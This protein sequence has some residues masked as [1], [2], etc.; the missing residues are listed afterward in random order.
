MSRLIKRFSFGKIVDRGEMPHFLEFQLNSY[1]DF[2]QAGIPPQKRENQGLENIFQEI[3]PIESSNGQLKLEYIWYEIHE[4]DKPLNDELECKKRRKTYAGQLKVRLRLINL[5]TEEIQETLVYFGEI[6]LMTDK[7]TFIINGAERVVVSQLHRSPGVTFNKELSIQTGKDIFIGKIIPYKGTWLEFETDKNDILNVKIDRRK[8]VLS[9]I[10]LKSVD[11]FTNNREIMDQFFES[12]ELE[13]NKLYEKY[14]GDDLQEVIKNRL[15][16]SFNKE[17][18]LDEKTGEFVLESEELIDEIGIEKLI[19]NKVEK[20]YYWEVKPEDRIIA[21]SLIHDHT[22]T[23]DEAVVEVF[24]KLRPGDLVT[25]DSARSLLK[26]MFFNP[27]RYDLANVGRYKIN[28][29]LKL[30]LP[31]NEI[32]LTKEDVMQTINYVRNLYNDDGYTDD[33]DNLSNR[34]VRG[35]GELLAIQVKGGM[36]KMAKMVKEKMTI[37][38]ITTL[39]PQSLLNTKP[40]NALILEFFGS[41][42]LSQFMDQSNPLAELTHKRRISALGPGGLSRERAGFEVRDVHN[43]HYGRICPIETPE[44]PNIGLIGSL[45]TYGKVNKYGFIETPFAKVENGKALL[46][47]VNYLGADEEEGLFI[48]QADTPVDEKGNILVEEVVCRYGEEIVH[49]V[50][51]KVH[52]LDVSPKQVV[53]VSA[54]LIP[55]LEHDDANRALMG[56]NMQRQAVPLLR[57]EAP[58]VG[59]GLERKVAV[60]SGAVMTS[61]ANGR[62]TSVDAKQIIVTD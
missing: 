3:F 45:A 5:K 8:K 4:N 17:D 21:N 46:D 23:S 47:K 38:D 53:S 1:E 14:K 35:V 43:S 28:K 15:E 44:G 25:V 57:T 7:A 11:F 10:F 22:K 30:D 16:G 19:E 2:I 61:K 50:K 20:I 51:E 29:R 27:Q 40:L 34:R 41:G 49:I 18:I 9:T 32:T 33:I 42:Q 12:K 37:Q 62:V 54:G 58:Y 48:A 26:Q 39:T 6:P 52:Y 24:K 59:T 13:L 60:D 55:F 56:S 31:E 36:M